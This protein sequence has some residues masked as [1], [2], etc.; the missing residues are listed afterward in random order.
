M[1]SVD[2]KEQALDFLAY[3]FNLGDGEFVCNNHILT[4]LNGEVIAIGG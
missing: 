1:F 3:S 4:Q 2:Y